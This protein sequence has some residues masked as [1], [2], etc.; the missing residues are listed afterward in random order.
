MTPPRPATG[1]TVPPRAATASG[2]AEP[3]Q[4]PTM[5]AA[6]VRL[7]AI[8][9]LRGLVIMLMALDHVRDFFS[10]A[11]HAP[12]DLHQTTVALFLTRWI[13]HYCAPTFVLLA[14]LSASLA[15]QRRT[16]ARLSRF[17]LSRGLWLVLLEATVVSFAWS[18]DP[19]YANGLTLQV[20][21]AIGG[22]MCA[23]AALVWLPTW[24]VG[25]CGV[26]MIAGHNLLDPIQPEQLGGW[27]PLWRMLHVPGPTPFGTLLYPLVPWVGVMALG[28]ALGPRYA[29]SA[30]A[31]RR[32]GLALGPALCLGFFLVRGLN[33][34]GD[35]APW[36]PQ[37]DAAFTV[38]S[39]LNVSKYPPSLSYL[40][41]TLGPALIAMHLFERTRGTFASVLCTFGQVPLFAY[42]LHIVLAHALSD[43]TA[44]AMGYA[45]GDR[46]V[47]G[48]GLAG[49][50]LAWLLVLATL[51]PACRWFA[52][53]KRRRA[54]WWLAYL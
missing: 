41:M 26:V 48:F 33:G 52:A 8:D 14:G 38:L 36:A 12:T 51:F 49:V 46:Q 27:A 42:V 28:Y 10:N 53:V 4:V 29:A 16:R 23:L 50:Y 15:G 43:L 18:F 7:A 32:I 54:D 11:P 17:L 25:L 34:Y 31:R 2:V 3:A 19:S 21:W 9:Q 39:F 6:P 35:P 44:S 47:W 24:A 22:S 1:V 40:L 13:T 20:I 30:Q 37:R 45:G 5:V